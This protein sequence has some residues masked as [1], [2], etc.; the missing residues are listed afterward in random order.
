MASFVAQLDEINELAERTPGFVWRLKGPDGAASSYIAFDEDERTIVNMSVWTS[1]E[2][3]RQYVYRS[4]H[5]AVY[6]DRRRW[7]EP[8]TGPQL[9]IW[10]S[11]AGYVPSI[12]EGRQRLELLKQ[13]GPTADAFTFKQPFGPPSVSTRAGDR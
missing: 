12:E 2:A 9:A 4:A 7:F 11:P 8:M 13:R 3:L 5:G 6:R 1:I 10:W